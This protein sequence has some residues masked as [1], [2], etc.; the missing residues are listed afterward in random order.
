ME[1]KYWYRSMRELHEM[2]QLPTL[3][4]QLAY[5]LLKIFLVHLFPEMEGMLERLEQQVP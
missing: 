4:Q 5:G 1:F 2:L 3:V